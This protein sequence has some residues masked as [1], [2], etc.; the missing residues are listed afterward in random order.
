MKHEYDRAIADYEAAIRLDPAFVMAIGNRGNAYRDKGDYDRAIAD[1]TT[2]IR[3][4]PDNAFSYANRC[5]AYG[6]KGDYD[7]AIA[8]YDA[9]IRLAPDLAAP[10]Y[11][12]AHAYRAKGDH[13]RAIADYGEAIRRAPKLAE[14]FINRGDIYR[15]KGDYDRAIADFDEVIR[16]A[17]KTAA[18]FGNRC[19]AYH[20]KG[21]DRRAIADCDE[22]IRLD[23]TLALAFNSRGMAYA[24]TGDND[25]ALADFDQALRLNPRLAAAF[26]NRGHVRHARG[27][28][29]L[30]IADFDQAVALDP[31]SALVLRNRGLVY[32][33]KGDDRRAIA[34]FDEALRLYPDDHPDRLL[35]RRLRG[36]ADFR[37]ADYRAA[38]GD[39]A[40][41]VQRQPTEPYPVLWLYLARAR[42]GDHDAMGRMRANARGLKSTDWP[43]PA[44]ELFIGRKTPQQTLASAGN[45]AE[46]CEAQFY[47]GEW[48]LLRRDRAAAR[49]A[50]ETATDGCPKSI[51]EYGG[52]VAELKRLDATGGTKPASNPAPAPK[53][54]ATRHRAEPRRARTSRRA[55]A[56]RWSV[57]TLLRNRHRVPA[58][59]SKDLFRKPVTTFRDHA[60]IHAAW[61]RAKNFST[62]PCS[63]SASLVSFC[64]DD[65]TWSAPRPVSP[66]AWLTPA[67]LADTSPVPAAACWTLRAISWVAAPCC[68]TAEAIAVAIW[69]ISVMVE[70]ML[71]IAPT[72]FLVAS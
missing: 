36:Y 68:S 17:P 65:S 13:G 1:F 64:A 23:P 5:K 42:A 59:S 37:L 4:D 45:P 7:R 35:L 62:S 12:R 24:T 58:S 38:A 18:A 29:D 43:S 16:L 48:H 60:F 71:S 22:A 49:R 20:D 21:D 32:G 11:S 72:A 27:E 26:N 33:A 51:V 67:M 47:I 56:V 8:D 9:A 61:T 19:L 46:R 6:D 31:K 44:V 53:A 34:D 28:Y 69:L 39:L 10:F 57:M 52:A 14:A 55:T 30:A 15:T 41:V 40:F 66:A 25:R 54:S 50:L 70:P 63:T 3:L 2:V